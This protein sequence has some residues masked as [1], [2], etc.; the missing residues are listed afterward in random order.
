MSEKEI[1][2][3]CGGRGFRDRRQM[4]A[5]VELAIRRTERSGRELVVVHGAAR[6]ADRLAGEVASDLGIA[7][8]VFPADWDRHGR[9][10]GYRRNVE[11]AE[12]LVAER[13][14]GAKVK[15]VAFPGGVGTQHMRT[16]AAEFD[17]AVFSPPPVK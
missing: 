7:T 17:L 11:M 10:A 13:Q 6:G 14:A 9:S 2:L 8:V 4:S 5:Y 12:Y 16:I 15:V 3:V 1:H